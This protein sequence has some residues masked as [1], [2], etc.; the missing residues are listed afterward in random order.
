MLKCWN[1]IEPGVWELVTEFGCLRI[2]KDSGYH[3]PES[4]KDKSVLAYWDWRDMY[5]IGW[6]DTVDEA[7]EACAKDL[8]R[9]VSPIIDFLDEFDWGPE[10]EDIPKRNRG[11]WVKI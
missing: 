7:E 11:K 2:A 3:R 1:E 4:S 8:E 5:Q 9:R 6:F 10:P